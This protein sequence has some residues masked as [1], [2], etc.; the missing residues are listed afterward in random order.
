MSISEQLKKYIPKYL[1]E[2]K[3]IALF[4]AT[5]IVF[6]AFFVAVYKPIG[7]I[8]NDGVLSFLNYRLYSIVLVLVGLV[9]FSLSR[10]LLQRVQKHFSLVVGHYL[11]WLGVEL[12]MLVILIT[13]VAWLINEKE[14]MS[15]D[16]LVSR[17]FID[18]IALLTMPYIVSILLFLLREKRSEIDELTQL[19]ETDSQMSND[20]TVDGSMQF[21]DKGGRLAFVTKSSNVLYIEAADN[22]T[23]IHYL[24]GEKEETFLLHNS[25]KNLADDFSLQCMVRCHRGF[26]VNIDN[27]KCLR[28]DGAGLVLEMA[29]SDRLIPVTKTYSDDLVMKFTKQ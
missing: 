25:L 20:K 22:Y 2:K 5:V 11:L 18:T 7:I 9:F 24:S 6:C 28:K 1:T 27:V 4:F 13:S 14:G 10:W 23:N 8:S 26:L 3:S 12:V 15:L 17:V 29:F 21:F 16:V 19:L